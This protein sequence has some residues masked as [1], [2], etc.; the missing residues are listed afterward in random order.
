MELFLELNS[1]TSAAAEAQKRILNVI[2]GQYVERWPEY[3]RAL[4][5]GISKL[6]YGERLHIAKFLYGNL[7]DEQ[8]V[9]TAMRHRLGNK[10]NHDH[11]RSYLADLARGKYNDSRD[12]VQIR[13]EPDRYMLNGVR[14]ADA[15]LSVGVR[16][17]NAWEAEVYRYKREHR[18]WPTMAE[19]SFFFH[20][21]AH[22]GVAGA[23]P[24]TP[25]QTLD[26]DSY[27]ADAFVGA[28]H[29]EEGDAALDEEIALDEKR[30]LLGAYDPEPPYYSSDSH[31]TPSPPP[32]PLPPAPPPPPPPPRALSPISAQNTYEDELYVG[33][34]LPIVR[35]AI[36][37]F[38]KELHA[39]N[40]RGMLQALL[41]LNF[42]SID[43]VLSETAEHTFI[44]MSSFH[45][46]FT[47]SPK[48][49]ADVSLCITYIRSRCTRTSTDAEH[50]RLYGY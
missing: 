20:G 39:L 18:R 48:I 12:Y 15:P 23:A 30:A 38:M 46:S 2:G 11:F 3:T 29:D 36:V 26:A 7:R 45:R 44:N 22:A 25:P 40:I 6:K 4:F 42:D 17:L 28:T 27:L 34:L 5:F 14:L 16:A 19:Q 9:Y 49:V 33:T 1:M 47:P 21:S 43:S 31:Y 13:E 35:R 41:A 8:L 32:F 37:P 50:D 10:G 24:T